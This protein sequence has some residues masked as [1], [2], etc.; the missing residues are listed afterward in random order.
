VAQ[1][2]SISFGVLWR[3]AL[4]VGALAYL[5]VMFVL[6]VAPEIR[7]L[8]HAEAHGVLSGDPQAVVRAT[9]T[10]DGM[11][12]SFRRT[13]DGW[14]AEGAEAPLPEKLAATLDRA[15]KFMHTANPVRR[16]EA[17]ELSAGQGAD[18]GLD[19]PQLSVSL[20]SGDG[21]RLD[22][23]FGKLSRDGLLQYMRLAGD[24]GVF[25]MS[26]FVGKEWDTVSKGG[27]Q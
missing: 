12:K 17:A 21:T 5:I 22:A 25:M 27:K 9:V 3:S 18:F 4:A 6:G 8:I 2:M 26:S 20:E 7:Q 23:D 19:Q 24:D 1:A 11:R 10:V 16:F 15:V 14:I 13:A